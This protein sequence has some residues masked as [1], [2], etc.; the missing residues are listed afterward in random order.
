MATKQSAPTTPS[1]AAEIPK[2]A[3]D[4]ASEHDHLRAAAIEEEAAK[5]HANGASPQAISTYLGSKGIIHNIGTGVVSAI[6]G[7]DAG[8][9]VGGLFGNL[10]DM[11]IERL[12]E[13]G[14]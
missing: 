7:P 13:R 14:S 6:I 4:S 9:A 5:L 10:E 12:N 11:G 1:T 3:V 2:K 8:K